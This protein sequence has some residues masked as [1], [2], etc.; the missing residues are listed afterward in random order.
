MSAVQYIRACVYIRSHCIY[1]HMYVCTCVSMQKEESD[2][3]RANLQYTKEEAY[4]T[5]IKYVYTQTHTHICACTCTYVC[6]YV[7]MC[8]HA[9]C[10]ELLSL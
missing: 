2:K 4:D 5:A 3:L 1:I 7:Y 9:N 6:M 10:V 8:V